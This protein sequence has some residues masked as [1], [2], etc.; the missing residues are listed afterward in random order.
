MRLAAH[1]SRLWL[2]SDVG[3][4]LRLR[5]SVA[6]RYDQFQPRVLRN[7]AAECEH[8]SIGDIRRPRIW[9]PIDGS[10]NLIPAAARQG[11]EYRVPCAVDGGLRINYHFDYCSSAVQNLVLT[12][13]SSVPCSASTSERSLSHSIRYALRSASRDLFILAKALILF[14]S[15]PWGSGWRKMLMLSNRQLIGIV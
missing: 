10:A 11:P 4:L 12:G 2:R 13:T 5:P 8:T 3:G 14:A 6:D 1:L 15:R 9:R 7:G